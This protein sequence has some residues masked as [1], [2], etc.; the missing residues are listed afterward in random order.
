M[1]VAVPPVPARLL[2]TRV[3]CAVLKRSPACSLRRQGW[4]SGSCPEPWQRWQHPVHLQTGDV[5][6]QGLAAEGWLTSSA[7]PRGPGCGLLSR[8]VHTLDEL[9][10]LEGELLQRLALGRRIRDR[11][12]AVDVLQTACHGS[13]TLGLLQARQACWLQD[14][15][16]ECLQSTAGPLTKLRSWNVRSS[17]GESGSTAQREMTWPS[18]SPSEGE[19]ME[20]AFCPALWSQARQA[21]LVTLLAVLNWQGH[22]VTLAGHYSDTAGL[23]A[24]PGSSKQALADL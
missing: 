1:R 11:N 17:M 16:T 2:W 9:A 13:G 24:G 21:Q 10:V 3:E 14:A 7:L 20:Q 8:T 19:V 12:P 23:K 4:R 15:G 6:L 22:L 5:K 18:W